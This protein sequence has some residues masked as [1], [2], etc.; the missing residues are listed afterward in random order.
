MI[1]CRTRMMISA[2]LAA[3]RIRAIL[4]SRSHRRSTCIGSVSSRPRPSTWTPRRARARRS[5]PCAAEVDGGFG[6][7]ALAWS[8]ASRSPSRF[9]ATPAS[10]P[11]ISRSQHCTR[12]RHSSDL[13]S[14]SNPATRMSD[15]FVVVMPPNRPYAGRL[16]RLRRLHLCLLLD[17]EIGDR[18]VPPPPRSVRIPSRPPRDHPSFSAARVV[19]RWTLSL[20][21]RVVSRVNEAP[22]GLIQWRGLVHL[23]RA[24]A[25]VPH[26]HPP[27]HHP[28]RKERAPDVSP[29]EEA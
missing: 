29:R 2:G 14:C 18:R 9:R 4:L 15:R 27:G 25:R 23:P 1:C 16:R 7:F 8:A 28:Q 12:S 22:A 20:R 10:T 3:E 26:E 21:R 6:R 17:R 19:S 11:R 24:S 5:L 13:D